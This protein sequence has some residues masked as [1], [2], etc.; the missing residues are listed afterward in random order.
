[1]ENHVLTQ[2]GWIQ[3]NGS[4]TIP[5]YPGYRITKDA[6]ITGKHGRL[7]EHYRGRVCLRKDGRSE[8]R[9][10][11][12]LVLETFV[13]PCPPGHTLEYLHGDLYRLRDIRWSKILE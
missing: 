5:E 7:M 12:R 8:N 1:M 11:A 6:K 2:S 3:D 13:G 9:C 4:K 10:I